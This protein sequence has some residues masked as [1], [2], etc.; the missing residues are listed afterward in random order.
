MWWIVLLGPPLGAL[1]LPIAA[2]AARFSF[3]PTYGIAVP[4]V[5]LV[6]AEFASQAPLGGSGDLDP[7]ILLAISAFFAFVAALIGAL[8]SWVLSRTRHRPRRLDETGQSAEHT[9]GE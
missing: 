1:A 4:V 3:G 6:A 2:T 7:Q 9:A 8:A 5:L